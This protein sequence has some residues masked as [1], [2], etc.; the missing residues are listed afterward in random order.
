MR[1]TID[2]VWGRREE[3][4]N[5]ESLLIA[6]LNA[7]EP[8]IEAEFRIWAPPEVFSVVSVA[9][10][11]FVVSVAWSLSKEIV[12]NLPGTIAADV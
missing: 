6:A 12:F 7:V 4:A 2:W 11:I 5:S 8:E 9:F 10:S 3:S 1:F